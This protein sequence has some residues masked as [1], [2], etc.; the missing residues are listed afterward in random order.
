M[1]GVNRYKESRTTSYK[2]LSRSVCCVF[3]SHRKSDVEVAK[4]VGRFLTDVVNVDIYLDENDRPL[5]AA[6]AS[7]DD[8]KI[9]EYIEKGIASSTHLLG[10]IS[11]STRG[12]WWVPYEIGA[13]RQN[14]LAIAHMLLEN[15]DEVPSYL[16]ISKLIKDWRELIGWT[17][18]LKGRHVNLSESYT[19]KSRMPI[20]G[21]PITRTKEVT[22]KSFW[23]GSR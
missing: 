19:Y 8:Q 18:N 23:V 4:A 13:A 6:V 11:E 14:G 15:V 1:A 16:R 5:L 9:V 21:L 10:I 3:I 2:S 22:Y 7:G 17:Q 12:S 20:P